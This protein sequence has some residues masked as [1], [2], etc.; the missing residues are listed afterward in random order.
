MFVKTNLLNLNDLFKLQISKLEQNKMTR[1][2]VEHK[3][4]TYASSFTHY[5]NLKKIVTERLRTRL[6]LNSFRYLGLR[7][8]SSFPES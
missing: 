8:W 7:F 1:F 3:S 6:G 5:K 4:F 2:D